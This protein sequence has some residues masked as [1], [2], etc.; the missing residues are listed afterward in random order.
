MDDR[1]NR[2]YT[3]SWGNVKSVRQLAYCF[4]DGEWTDVLLRQ[5]SVNDIVR[6]LVSR[7]ETFSEGDENLVA[8]FK[9]NWCM[10][11]VVIN[12]HLGLGEDECVVS[13]VA[14]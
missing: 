8:G 10:F 1:Y 3:P 2:V 14:Q 6:Q 9:R 4:H 12:R 7:C 11:L 13:L 5:L